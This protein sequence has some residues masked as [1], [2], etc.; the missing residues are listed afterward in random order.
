MENLYTVHTK[1]LDGRTYYFIKKLLKLTE[2]KGLADVVVGYGMHTDFDKA[3]SIAGIFDKMIKDRMLLE[4]EVRSIPQKPLAKQPIVIPE[5][6]NR[7]LAER[8]AEV[9]N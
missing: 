7:W 6:V 5:T 2:F 4:L 8:G 9:L 3:C 1:L